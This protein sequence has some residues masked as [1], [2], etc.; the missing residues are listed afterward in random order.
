M[1]DTNVVTAVDHTKGAESATSGAETQDVKREIVHE[2][3]DNKA[4]SV[5]Q[6]ATE[7]MAQG[8]QKAKDA[9]VGKGDHSA[10]PAADAAPHQS[11]V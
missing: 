8:V 3:A 2:N 11:H 10:P 6:K 9:V 7:A 1:A 4:P 5:M